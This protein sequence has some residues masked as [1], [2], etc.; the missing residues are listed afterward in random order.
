MRFVVSSLLIVLM[1]AFAGAGCQKRSTAQ[2]RLAAI[3]ANLESLRQVPGRVTS[4]DG[5]ESPYTAYFQQMDL[6]VV[7]ELPKEGG[8]VRNRYYYLDGSLFF[9]RQFRDTS[10]ARQ[11]S[12]DKRGK[13]WNAQPEPVTDDEVRLVAGRAAELRQAAMDRAG[14]MF[15]FPLMRNR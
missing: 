1:A 15:V 14:N 12:V 10:L 4:S 13:T 3:D 8:Q 5:T 11:F 7:E 6:Q 9:Y 2:G